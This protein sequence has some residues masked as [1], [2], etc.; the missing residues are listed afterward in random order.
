MVPTIVNVMATS[1]NGRI[2]AQLLE[3]DDERERL[4]LSHPVDRQFLFSE[5]H[6]SDAIIV[7][8]S[9]LRASGACI[10]ERGLGGTFP[11]WYVLAK[12]P[13][14]DELPF[15]SQT[16]IPRVMIS[17]RPL[18]VP[19]KSGVDTEICAAENPARFVLNLLRKAGHKRALLFGGGVV[20]RFFYDE[21]L[22][23]E[24]KLTVSPLFIAGKSTPELISPELARHVRFRLSSSQVS[25]SFV[26]LNY[27]VQKS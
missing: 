4:G 26:F 8:A 13:L 17:P 20:N 16:D 11:T 14:P 18:P 22:V 3:S 23:D 15:W 25:E 7:G 24:L 6:K 10:A 27:Q 19:P 5:I 2:G 21:G 12:T 1:L 9:S